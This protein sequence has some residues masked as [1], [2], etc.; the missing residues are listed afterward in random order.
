MGTGRDTL[1]IIAWSVF[2]VLVI[3][4]AVALYAE[5]HV[6]VKMMP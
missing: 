1:A 2:W 4:G 6:I 5:W 3:I